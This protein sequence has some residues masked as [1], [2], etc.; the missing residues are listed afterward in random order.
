M[1]VAF[2]T[3]QLGSCEKWPSGE[4]QRKQAKK[5]KTMQQWNGLNKGQLFYGIRFKTEVIYTTVQSVSIVTKARS[6]AEHSERRFS[7][8][9]V[10]ISRWAW[11]T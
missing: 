10:I 9:L 5:A 8:H 7:D 3:W 2:H 11:F 6:T 1:I 4:K